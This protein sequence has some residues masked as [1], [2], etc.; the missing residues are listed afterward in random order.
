MYGYNELLARCG[1]ESNGA[2]G[3]NLLATALTLQGVDQIINNNG[4]PVDVQLTL[5]GKISNIPAHYVEVVITEDQD[6]NA[7]ITVNGHVREAGLFVQQLELRTSITTYTGS[8]Q[9]RIQDEV[10]NLKKYDTQE[11]ELLYH[12]NLGR[13]FLNGNSTLEVPTKRACLRNPAKLKAGQ[14]AADYKTCIEW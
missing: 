1:L 3:I 2:P 13:P 9:I 4:N 14:P 8:N 7:T 10:K 5:H 12:I 6:G 11:L